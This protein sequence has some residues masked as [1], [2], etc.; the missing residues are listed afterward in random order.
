M[1]RDE[2]LEGQFTV[3]QGKHNKLDNLLANLKNVKM[4]VDCF[5]F[6]FLFYEYHFTTVKLARMC[7]NG[8][9]HCRLME[10]NRLSNLLP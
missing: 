1:T 9:V 10:A 3:F 7:L 8:H 2:N 4:C 5:C 6:V